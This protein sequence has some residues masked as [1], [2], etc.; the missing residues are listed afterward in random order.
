MIPEPLH[1]WP[2]GEHSPKTFKLKPPPEF[3]DEDF[4]DRKVFVV[5]LAGRMLHFQLLARRS[6]LSFLRL[7]LCSLFLQSHCETLYLVSLLLLFVCRRTNSPRDVAL[8]PRLSPFVL[9]D[10]FDHFQVKP[11]LSET[12]PWGSEAC[13]L[14]TGCKPA[15]VA[16][17]V[18]WLHVGH[19][20]S[21]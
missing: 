10:P 19:S 2:F 5:I 9:L 16:V 11:R 7:V 6:L 8:L 21:I 18:W 13:C 3:P 20:D 17:L 4:L 1:R 12:P 15:H 14:A